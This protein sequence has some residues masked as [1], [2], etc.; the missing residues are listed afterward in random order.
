MRWLLVVAPLA[1]LGL[2]GAPRLVLDNG[3]ARTPIWV[4]GFKEDR[5]GLQ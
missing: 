3:V 4:V 2:T 5:S 1:L